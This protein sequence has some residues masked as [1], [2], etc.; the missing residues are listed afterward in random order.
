MFCGVFDGHGPWGHFVAK[1]VCNSMPSTLLYKW[2]EMLV[3]G[4]T[5]KIDKEV[6]RFNL[7]Q[8]SFIKTCADIDQDLKQ[9]KKIDS[10]YSGT[11]ALA[12]TRQ[13]IQD[14]FNQRWQNELVR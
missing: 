5:D 14:R 4:S 3:E 6:D 8:H 2:Q 7:W 13:V 12:V 10:V 1:R 9:Y 11:T